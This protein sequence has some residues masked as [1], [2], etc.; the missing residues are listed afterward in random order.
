MPFKVSDGCVER[1]WYKGCHVSDELCLEQWSMIK[2]GVDRLL[3]VLLALMVPVTS[4]AQGVVAVKSN[5]LYGSV[6]LAPNIAGETAVSPNCTIDISFG[7]NGWNRCGSVDDNRK[8]AHSLLQPE[9]RYFPCEVFNGHFFGLHGI[10]CAYNISDHHIPLIIGEISKDYRYE[11]KGYG[12]GLSYG[13]QL[14]L[15]KRWNLEFELGVGYVRVAYDLHYSYKCA[16]RIAYKKGNYVGPTRVGVSIA[17]I[18][19]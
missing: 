12:F 4:V 13:Y 19:N 16:P 5:L 15:S 18:I 1:F 7:Y 17:F 10:Y 2:V 6:A 9:F 8:M 11:G 14:L 3:V